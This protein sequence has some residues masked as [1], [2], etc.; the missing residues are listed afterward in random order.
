MRNKVDSRV[1]IRLK[2]KHN[3][4]SI[5]VSKEIDSYGYEH[6]NSSY[7]T[8]TGVLATS[9]VL[10]LI[11]LRK[12][13]KILDES[14][15]HD[16][17][18][19]TSDFYYSPKTAVSVF[20]LSN[21]L[22]TKVKYFYENHYSKNNLFLEAFNNEVSIESNN[23]ERDFP[24]LI[25]WNQKFEV[26]HNDKVTLNYICE[27]SFGTDYSKTQIYDYVVWLSAKNS[28]E[29]LDVDY[30]GLDSAPHQ[31]NTEEGM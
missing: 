6:N 28:A 23:L 22:L 19:I 30:L 11:S 2:E 17:H 4:Y 18:Q 9:L 29:F 21:L 13:Y 10:S 24:C 20:L 5:I 16:M 3:E 7:I 1:F 15:L 12:S 27:T 8:Y 31:V 14:P 26:V 25:D